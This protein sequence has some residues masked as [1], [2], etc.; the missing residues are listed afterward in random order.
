MVSNGAF[1]S[2]RRRVGGRERRDFKGETG[3]KVGVWIVMAIK[4]K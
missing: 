3:K 2:L 1:P 4:D